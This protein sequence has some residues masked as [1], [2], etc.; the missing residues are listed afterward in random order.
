M[1]TKKNIKINEN[2]VI[3][4]MSEKYVSVEIGCLRFLDSYRVLDA[5]LDNLSTTLKSCV[6]L[7]A[8]GMEDDLFKRKLPCP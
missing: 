1:T 4:K 6:S 7:D 2:D 5:S 8:N 3:A